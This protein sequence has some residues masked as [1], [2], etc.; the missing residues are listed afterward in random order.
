MSLEEKLGKIEIPPMPQ[1][2]GKI[3]QIDEN[4]I[5]VSSTQME[6]IIAVDPALS[7]KILKIAN[8][9]FYARS[10][11]VASL[12]QAITLLGFK[13]IKSLTLLVS[14][15][16]MFLKKSAAVEIQKEIWMRSVLSALVGKMVA[17]RTGAR[18]QKD[19]VFMGALLKNIGQIYIN[20][21]QPDAYSAIFR[22]SAAATDYRK[23]RE[24]EQTQFGYTATE[25]SV[26][27]MKYWNFP[28]ELV[29][30]AQNASFDS[31]FSA[32][33]DLSKRALLGEII[34]ILKNLTSNIELPVDLI[35]YY[36]TQFHDF[37]AHLEMNEKDKNYFLGQ[38]DTEIREDSF[39][40]F[41]EELFSM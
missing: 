3:I 22:N 34:V 32:L 16:G 28:E 41:V 4:N 35:E 11:R 13:T 37:A 17:E 26:Y 14:A 38:I 29:R 2:V 39:Y 7:F 36:T 15:A 25:V 33:D 5:E 12:S 40:T 18:A 1:V 30:V 31:D 9:A 27:I 6:T 19:D 10:A 24:L 20:N 8:S 21:H 23:L